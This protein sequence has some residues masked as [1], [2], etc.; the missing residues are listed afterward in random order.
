[1]DKLKKE[2]DFYLNSGELEE[3]FPELSGDWEKDK[4][5]FKAIHERFQK[6]LDIDLN[7]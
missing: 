4:K 1:M 7:T 6:A 5:R 3:I 2:Y